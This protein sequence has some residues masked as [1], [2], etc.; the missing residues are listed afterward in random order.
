MSV[1][2][3]S[4]SHLIL[5]FRIKIWHKGTGKRN[6]KAF[7]SGTLKLQGNIND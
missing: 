7:F 4:P 6:C 2:T 1:W 3:V 5:I